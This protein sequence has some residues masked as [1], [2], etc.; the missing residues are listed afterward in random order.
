MTPR[1]LTTRPSTPRQPGLRRQRVA[2]GTVFGVHGAA[3]GTFAARI[4]SIAEHLHLGSGA[5]GLALFMPAVGS[6]TIMPLTGRVIHRLGPRM[7]LQVLLG[8]L[9]IVLA[10]P[11]IMPSLA[12]LCVSMAICGATAGTADVAMNAQGSALEHRMGT[13]IMSSLHGLWSVGGFVAAG[14]ATVA[15]RFSVGAPA[16]LAIMALALL[17]IGQLAARSLPAHGAGGIEEPVERPRFSFPSGVVLIIALVGFCSVFGEVSGSDWSAIYMRDV[18]HSGHATAA[19]TYGVFAALMAFGRLTG[20]RVVR[21]F[22]AA[23]TVQVSALAGTLGVVLVI[24]ALATPLTIIGFALL[25]IGVATVV[26]LAFAAAGRIGTK[27][28]HAGAG[29][30]IAGVATIAYGAGL[31]APGAIGGLASVTSL[32]WS[33]VL[34]AVLVAVIVIAGRALGTAAPSGPTFDEAAGSG[35]AVNA[36]MGDDSGAQPTT[37]T[38]SYID[39]R[40]DA[41]RIRRG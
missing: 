39:I 34:V 31:A 25:G 30:A 33:F 3:A 10:L 5:L 12:L 15:T 20:D 28:G 18:M 6:M 22:G 32:T 21:R 24:L 1:Q 29:N 16:H 11:A 26:P 4:P 36:S 23:L 40:A 14:I 17:V 41:A 35:L 2:I 38:E 27:K 8:A 7:A 19:A 9:C 13:S 37:E